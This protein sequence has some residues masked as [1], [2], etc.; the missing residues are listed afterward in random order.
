MFIFN[1]F[2]LGNFFILQLHLLVLSFNVVLD[3]EFIEIKKLSLYDSFFVVLDTGLYLYNFN[4]PNCSIIESFNSSVY[5][6]N[7]NRVISN[8]PN[9]NEHYYTPRIVNKFLFIFN[10]SNNK[11]CSFI[12]DI[13]DNSDNHYYD[14]LPLDLIIIK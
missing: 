14:L 3:N 11:T 12:L 10:E 6:R 9:H 8:E 5:K 1:E 7:N 4:S 2:K 13:F